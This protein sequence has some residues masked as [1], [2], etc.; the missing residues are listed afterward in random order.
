ISSI[1]GYPDS[2]LTNPNRV[3]TASEIIT[4][5]PPP[6]FPVGTDWSYCN[7][8]YLLAGMIAES[9]TGQSYSQL[10]RN[11][12]LTP[13]QLDSTFLD[14]YET[15]LFPV[16]HPWQGGLN[17]HSTPRV[18][19]NSAAWAAGAMYSISEEMTH[20]YK[21]LFNGQILDSNSLNEITTFVG[22]GNY[23]MGISQ[24]TVLGRTIWT[25]G[26]NIWGGY[27]SSMM[28]DPSTGIIICVLI[29]QLPHQANLVSIELLSTL[30]NNP[31]SFTENNINEKSLNIFPNPTSNIVT[32]NGIKSLNDVSYI[33]LFDNKGTL[34]KNIGINDTQVDLTSFTAGIYFIKI[35]HQLG[36]VRYKVIKLDK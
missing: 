11:H 17:N 6:L 26:G 9:A 19:I 10:L 3:F 36:S 8:N 15:I 30:I 33:H 2:M 4:W 12:I 1:S 35:K 21:T 29:N 16:A 34:L 7:T 13:L 18:S 31:L 20:W 28:F 32:L 23:G 22:S 5:V 14:V 24:K 25:H 27:S